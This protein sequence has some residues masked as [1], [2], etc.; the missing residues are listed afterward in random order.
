[1]CIHSH[2]HRKKSSEIYNLTVKS[3]RRHLT[4]GRE[5]G[6][7]GLQGQR[8]VFSAW[9]PLPVSLASRTSG[10][11]AGRQGY[12]AGELVQ[13]ALG[14]PGSRTEFPRVTGTQTA[15]Q[16]G[17]A[18]SLKPVH[19]VGAGP[20]TAGDSRRHGAQHGPPPTGG[21]SS[22]SLPP[23]TGTGLALLFALYFK[24]DILKYSSSI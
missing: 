24:L 5:D 3:S 2:T 23:V 10:E 14:Q 12:K 8:S 9:D 11:R 16:A 17:A 22:T 21:G 19:W 18:P 15:Q 13:K 1:M 7:H 6:L 20:G 4:G